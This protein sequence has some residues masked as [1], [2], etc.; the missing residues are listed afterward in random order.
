MEYEF[1]SETENGK[2]YLIPELEGRT[3][4]NYIVKINDHDDIKEIIPLIIITP[5]NLKLVK[6]K[7]GL[8]RIDP[9]VASFILKEINHPPI[10]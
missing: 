8:L 6:L 9:N 1:E 3:L 4:C 5:D 7:N 10:S 2:P